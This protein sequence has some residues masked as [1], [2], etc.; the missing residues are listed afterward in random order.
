[1]LD[2]GGLKNDIKTML[3]QL[4]T[5]DE[6]EAAIEKFAT[7]MANAMTVFVRTAT[8]YAT[9]GDVTAAAMSNQGG[10]V[11]AANNLESQLL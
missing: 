4:K 8:I 11:A 7:D 1:M 6:R 3:D 9:P 5:M 10:P 2:T